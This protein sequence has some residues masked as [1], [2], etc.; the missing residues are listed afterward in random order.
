MSVLDTDLVAVDEQ[1]CARVAQWIAV[2]D[3]PPD[4]EETSLSGLSPTEVGDFY[5]FLVAICHQTTPRGFP[6]LLGNVAGRERRGW[7]YLLGRF[8]HLVAK[9]RDLLNPAFWREMTGARLEE[10]FADPQYGPRLI[11]PQ[12]RADLICNLGDVMHARGWTHLQ[13]L[14]T[15]TQGRIASDNPNLLGLLGQ[16]DAYRDPV[17]KKAFYLLALMQNHGIWVYEDPSNL[18]PP[19]DYHE[20]R[21]HLRLGTVTIL[22]DELLEKLRSNTPVSESEDLAIRSA[23]FDAISRI[24][25]LSRINSPSRLHYLFWNVFRSCCQRAETHCDGC[26][27]SCPLPARYVPL[28]ISSEG[29]RCPFHSVCRA[30]REPER[31]TLLEHT[32]SSSYDFH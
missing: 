22:G 8:E 12:R 11:E 14:Y 28:A 30:A 21:G 13:A 24:S 29:R 9:E 31:R 7:D 27:P 15:S 3:I 19:V 1:A 5:L 16:F 23:V 26:P 4:S 10:M 25:C 17:H 32:V 20:I 18:G 2:R 6:P